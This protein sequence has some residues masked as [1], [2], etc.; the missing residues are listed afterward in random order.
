[1]SKIL[2][3]EDDPDVNQALR[4]RLEASG[5]EVCSAADGLQG[6]STAVKERPDLMLLDIS[7]PAGNGFSI[8]ERARAHT[9]L[10]DVPVIF[11]TA[12]KRED[13][14]D[15]AFELGAAGFFE[16]PYESSDLIGAI[17]DTLS[18]GLPIRFPEM[19]VEDR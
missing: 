4:I 19:G 2:I 3:V 6:L 15:R 7:M 11:L 14:R 17:S 16:K 18:H 5:Y 10:E 12:S 13:L 8:V 1:M 9:D